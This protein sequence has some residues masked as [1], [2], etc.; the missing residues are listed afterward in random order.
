MQMKSSFERAISEGVRREKASKTVAEKVHHSSTITSVQS[1]CCDPKNERSN[2]Q[3]EREKQ[4]NH[5]KVI[6]DARLL[7]YPARTRT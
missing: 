1:D 2:V 5:S 3:N 7:S 4:G 6:V